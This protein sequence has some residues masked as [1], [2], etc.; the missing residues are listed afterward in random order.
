MLASRSG[1]GCRLDVRGLGHVHIMRP[2]C[3]HTG[4]HCRIFGGLSVTRFWVLYK[5]PLLATWQAK[6]QQQGVPPIGESPWRE[7]SAWD[8]DSPAGTDGGC[9]VLKRLKQ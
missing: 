4:R 1:A 3:G 2:R 8:G 5:A 6:V 7:G 9:W